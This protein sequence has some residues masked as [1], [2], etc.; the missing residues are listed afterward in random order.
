MY[1]T[2]EQF[3]ARL[4]Y[5]E[6]LLYS[7]DYS[8]IPD[9]TYSSSKNLIRAKDYSLFPRFEANSDENVIAG[10]PDR[11]LF[12]ANSVKL[13]G[14]IKMS[15]AGYIH[16]QLE[17]PQA[18]FFEH[19]RTAW[20]GIKD[21][22]DLISPLD[23]K[24]SSHPWFSLGSVYHGIFKQCMVNKFELAISGGAEPVDMNFGIVATNYSPE[25]AFTIAGL[26]SLTYS[27]EF[28]SHSRRVVYGRD[29][30]ITSGATDVIGH[31]GLPDA[32]NS[33]FSKGLNKPGMS[34]L[35]TNFS[36]SIENN[37]EP[38][39][40][41]RSH[42]YLDHRKR[43]A[44][45]IFPSSYVMSSARRVSGQ[46]EWYGNIDKYTFMEK[47]IGPG[48]IQNNESLIINCGPIGIEIK[49]LVWSLSEKPVGQDKVKRVAR[50]MATT[51][52]ELVIPYYTA[53]Y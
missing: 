42:E 41:S 40:T 34:T 23:E 44:E 2:P 20:A 31:F 30:I 51:D 12:I 10:I 21:N 25:S 13:E 14:D 26:E 33:T 17:Y 35:L 6:L 15:L 50:F 43:F 29:C 11:N 9:F 49:N 7:S 28:L 18:M 32:N 27:P 22:G 1:I 53:D 5:S 46:I 3:V 36:I 47:L 19:M 8:D 37:L 38:V 48:S 24:L 4:G 45:N 52:S 16:G 39:Y